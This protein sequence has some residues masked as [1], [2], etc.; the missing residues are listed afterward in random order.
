MPVI[1]CNKC[2]KSFSTQWAEKPEHLD[3]PKGAVVSERFEVARNF[4]N[5]LWNAARFVMINLEG[6]PTDLPKLDRSQLPLEDRWI[7]SRLATHQTLT[8]TESD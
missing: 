1:E 3:L 8:V 2:N 6:M 7:L 5:K 4:C